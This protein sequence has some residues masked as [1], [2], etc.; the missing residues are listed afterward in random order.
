MAR[1]DFEGAVIGPEVNGVRYAS[2]AT[3]VHLAASANG[4]CSS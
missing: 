1:F 3:L 4:E 2:H